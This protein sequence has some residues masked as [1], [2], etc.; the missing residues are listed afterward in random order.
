MFLRL[1]ALVSMFGLAGCIGGTTYGTGVTQEAQL[2]SDVAG[3]VSLGSR[4]RKEPIDYSARP[5]LVRAPDGTALPQPAD[6]AAND[7]SFPVD[8]EARRASLLSGANTSDDV[9]TRIDEGSLTIEGAERPNIARPKMIGDLD[10]DGGTDLRK[11]KVAR[12]RVIAA[13]RQARGATGSGPRRYLTDPPIEYRTPSDS[14]AVGVV[15]EKEKRER[16]VV[17]DPTNAPAF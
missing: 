2:L 4:E 16:R 13:R 14:A 6:G 8:P 17:T 9:T 12:E 5:D 7:G 11:Q 15:G 10:R 3:L 1:I